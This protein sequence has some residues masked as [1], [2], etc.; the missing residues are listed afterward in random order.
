[1]N[2][3]YALCYFILFQKAQCGMILNIKFASF[4]CSMQ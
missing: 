4:H 2:F 3:T 1:M